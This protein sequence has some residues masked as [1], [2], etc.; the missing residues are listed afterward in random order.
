MRLQGRETVPVT[1]RYPAA[2]TAASRAAEGASTCPE[3][4]AGRSPEKG[5]KLQDRHSLRVAIFKKG[6]RKEKFTDL[7]LIGYKD[8]ILP[9]YKTI[10]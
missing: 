9:S 6:K 3:A 7:N 8:K 4:R 5:T 2:A 1:L 10:L